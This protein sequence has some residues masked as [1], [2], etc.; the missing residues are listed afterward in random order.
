MTNLGHFT[1]R[2]T[3]A[4]IFFKKKQKQEYFKYKSDKVT[5]AYSKWALC[6]LPFFI[7]LLKSPRFSWS[8]SLRSYTS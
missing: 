8:K 4:N 6:W 7:A 2:K 3:K 5:F 1:T